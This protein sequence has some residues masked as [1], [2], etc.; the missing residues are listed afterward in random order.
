MYDQAPQKFSHLIL[1]DGSNM[2][3]GDPD[4]VFVSMKT[5]VDTPQ[6]AE[7]MIQFFK[8]MLSKV[9]DEKVVDRVMSNAARM[10]RGIG[11][12][13]APNMA[14]WDAVKFYEI[15]SRV[16]IPICLVQSTYLNPERKRIS[17]KQGDNSPFIQYFEKHIDDLTINIIEGSGH[18]PMLE[19]ADKVND[20]INNFLTL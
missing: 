1:V 14:V 11:K 20:C 3:Q 19:K 2:G 15:L 13:L 17:L 18:F 12:K 6:Y 7:L 5:F 16:T 10:P 9:T 4:E 8:D